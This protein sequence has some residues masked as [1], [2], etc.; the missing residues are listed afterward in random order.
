[1]GSD[2]QRSKCPLESAHRVE[3]RPPAPAAAAHHANARTCRAKHACELVCSGPCH[4][5]TGS[6]RGNISL[7]AYFCPRG[8]SAV[9]PAA[10][11]RGPMPVSLPGRGTH[12]GRPYWLAGN[13]VLAGAGLICL[14]R[15]LP[16]R[17][18]S[19]AVFQKMLVL[20]VPGE[21]IEPPTNGLQNRCSTAELTRQT[22][23]F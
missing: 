2:G 4:A 19:A 1:M 17:V 5:V 13:A 22:R 14:P 21:G 16:R 6:R 15:C 7:Q 10:Q 23:H 20:L 3:P 12:G 11:G 18:S 9:R 8:A